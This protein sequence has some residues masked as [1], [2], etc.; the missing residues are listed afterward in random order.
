MIELL[1]ALNAAGVLNH[2]Q[3]E[4]NATVDLFEKMF[5][6]DLGQYHRSFLELRE[7]KNARTKF[8]DF[9][10]E[11]LTRKMDDADELL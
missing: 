8:L 2:G 11:V 4:L 3:L 7:R 1:Y 6:V 10:K 5:N 9:L